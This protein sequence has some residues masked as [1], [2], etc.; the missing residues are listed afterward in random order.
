MMNKIWKYRLHLTDSQTIDMPCGAEIL[1]VQMQDG[2]VCMWALCNT[3]AATEPRHIVIIG[4]GNPIRFKTGKFIGTVQSEHFV[5]HVF[6]N[7]GVS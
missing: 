4:T 3:D 7:T 2:Y 1:S 5:W 6:D